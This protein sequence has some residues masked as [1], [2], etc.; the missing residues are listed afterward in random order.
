[1]AMQPKPVVYIVDDEPEVREALRV[2]VEMMDLEPRCYASGPEFLSELDPARIDNGCLVVDLKMPEM[3]GFELLD[4]LEQRGLQLPS[5]MITGHGDVPAAVRAMKAGAVDFLEK[6]YR[7]AALRDCIAEALEADRQT[8]RA[9]LRR[10]ELRRRFDSLTPSERDVLNLTV[11]GIPD[12]VIAARL[13][14]SRRT[15]QL[16][17]ASLMKKLQADS[18]VGLVHLVHYLRDDAEAV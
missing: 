12:K 18:R 8:R 11:A 3:N 15:V 16:R 2:M 5:I 4:A 1:M 7:P 10:R 9:T 13:S 17:R 14:V 6:P